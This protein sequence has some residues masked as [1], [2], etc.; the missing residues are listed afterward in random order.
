NGVYNVLVRGIDDSGN[1]PPAASAKKVTI[2]VS[3][4]VTQ[5]CPCNL[6][7]TAAPS[8]S[9]MNDNNGGIVLGTRF[10]A[11]ANGIVTGIRFYKNSGN[12]GTHTGLLYNNTGTLLAQATF[13][14]ETTTG[15]QQVNFSTPVNIT[16]N[17]T[18]VA[19]YFSGSGFYSSSTGYF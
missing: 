13:T 9:T 18:Y 2:T 14:G 4:N 17:Q 12:S 11:T 7:G 8:V 6:F 1:Y 5:N 3:I 19:A 15:W 10:R 16:G